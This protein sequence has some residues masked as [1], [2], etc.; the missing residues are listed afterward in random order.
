MVD[1]APT[2]VEAIRML[3]EAGLH[4]EAAAAA[5]AGLAEIERRPTPLYVS[6]INE[7]LEVT[8]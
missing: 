3:K 4:E 8:R 1:P 6:M 5:A 2:R 7:A